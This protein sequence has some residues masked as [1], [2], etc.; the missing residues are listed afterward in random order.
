M[1]ISRE[2]NKTGYLDPH[3][4]NELLKI[5]YIFGGEQEVVFLGGKGS[6][7]RRTVLY[8][9]C[10]IGRVDCKISFRRDTEKKAIYKDELAKPC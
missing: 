9:H 1:T 3:E 4:I 10:L 7:D 5:F 8:N 2:I 6:Y